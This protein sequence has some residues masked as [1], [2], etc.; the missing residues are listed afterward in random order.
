MKEQIKMKCVKIIKN[1]YLGDMY[2]VPKDCDIEIAVARELF[3]DFVSSKEDID[4]GYY[5]RNKTIYFDF[6]DFP[7]NEKQIN[8]KLIQK[9]IEVVSENIENKKIFVHCIWGINRSPSLIFLYLI[10]KEIYPVNNL[11]KSLNKFK[12]IYP[13]FHMN[14][15]WFKFVERYYPFDSFK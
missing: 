4:N 2:S 14:P 15:G 1:L 12:K 9:F 5:W 8:V 11:M 13:S 6:Y 7:M 3:M 10:V